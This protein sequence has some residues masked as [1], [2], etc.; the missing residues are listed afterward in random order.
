MEYTEND[1]N[2]LILEFAEKELYP[3]YDWRGQLQWN[4]K[5]VAYALKRGHANGYKQKEERE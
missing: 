5:L 1:A 4:R 3:H 2:K